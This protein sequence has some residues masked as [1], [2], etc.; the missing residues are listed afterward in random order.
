MI[1]EEYFIDGMTCASCSSTIEKATRKLDGVEESNVNLTTNKMTIVYDETKL[2]RETIEVKVKKTGYGIRFINP[3]T[4]TIEEKKVESD[5]EEIEEK[6]A[7]L[8]IKFLVVLFLSLIY[9][10]MAGLL[11]LPVI[12]FIDKEVYPFNWALTQ[13]L[14]TIPIMWLG[15]SFIT[16]GIKTLF[17]LN[18]NMDSL[19]A[20]SVVTSF[21]YSLAQ[22]FFIQN[23][24]S[25][26]ETLYF[27]AAAA[28]ISFISVGKYLERNNKRKTKSAIKALLDLTP[29]TALLV[30]DMETQSYE[31]VMI[32]EVKVDDILFVKEGT[33]IP[34]DGIIVKGSASLDES[35]ITGESIPIEK[36]EGDKVIGGSLNNNGNIYIKVNKVGSETT[37]SQIIKFVEDAQGKKAP[38]SKIADRVS[39]VFVPIVIVIAFVAAAFWAIQGQSLSFVLNVFTSVLVI[40]CPCA[41]GLATPTAIMVSTGLGANNGILVRTGEAL[42]LI[43]K[44][45]VVIFDKTGTITEGKP[46]VT[47][48]EIIDKSYDIKKLLK[49]AGSV[50]KTSAHPLSKAIVEEMEENNIE[51]N[52][53]IKKTN[54]IA[55]KGIVAVLDDDSMVAIGNEKLMTL[56]NVNI[57]AFKEKVKQS[58]LNGNTSMYYSIN[59]KIVAILSVADTI[60]DDSKS[61]IAKLKK[62]GLEVVMLTGDNQYVAANIANQVGIDIVEANVLP[63]EKASV[64]EKYQKM[65]KT[66][67]MVGDGINDAPSLAQADIGFA[68]GNGS[69]IAIK[70]ADV[71]LMKSKL[72]DVYKT[73]RLSSLTITN[74]KQNLFWAFFYNTAGIPIAAGVFYSFGGILLNPIMASLAMSL[75]SVFVISNALR[76]KMKKLS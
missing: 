1:K 21:V 38:I 60:K 51:G 63:T 37:L 16:N 44:A 43:H 8:N 73:Y 62:K 32:S 14:I 66:V 50:E 30:S 52:L 33:S 3:D 67:I 65:N 40:A 22:M 29:Q 71:V 70:G 55:G 57:D 64:V 27:D 12:P 24:P 69:D 72:T 45:N 7:L 5:S 20:I 15:R 6:K 18:P 36:T 76:L 26:I 53:V 58:S 48:I 28:I 17:H 19:V 47:N 42:E 31:E 41:L 25:V 34:T 4:G 46:K 68:I 23:Y 59:E 75:S 74:I 13:L 35:L 10:T 54:N 39:G 56:F 2:K 11:R 9:V 61:A 49:I